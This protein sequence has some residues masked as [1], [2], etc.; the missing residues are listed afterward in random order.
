MDPTTCQFTLRLALYKTPAS[1]LTSK[2]FYAMLAT[3]PL[4]NQQ[5]GCHKCK[6]RIFHSTIWKRRRENQQVIRPP[7][8]A[9]SHLLSNSKLALDLSNYS[10]LQAK[11]NNSRSVNYIQIG[12]KIIA[13]QHLLQQSFVW[14]ITA[15][16]ICCLTKK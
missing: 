3:Y 15:A 9:E 14:K 2:P 8:I 7:G 16:F 13:G 1:L 10:T 5:C 12:L 4:S 11:F 6:A